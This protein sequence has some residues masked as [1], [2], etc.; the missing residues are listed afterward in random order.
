MQKR[1]KNVLVTALFAI[2]WITALSLGLGALLNY[3]SAPGP[4][5]TI[6]PSWPS[7]SKI[8]RATD[9]YTLVMLAHPHCPCTRASIG[10][11]AQVMARLQGKIRAYVLLLKPEDSGTDWEDTDLRRSTAQIPGVEILVDTNGAEAGRFGAE[12]SGH[13]FL[14]DSA[15]RLLFNGGITASRGHS[16]D[17]AGESAILSLVSNHST[18]LAKTFVF[19]CSLVDDSRKGMKSR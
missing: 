18:G 12:T 1:S 3:D 16:G 10:E 17:N 14:F 8:Q 13:T 6:P 19:G 11:L 7:G 9:G 5:G 4:V 15:G 2:M